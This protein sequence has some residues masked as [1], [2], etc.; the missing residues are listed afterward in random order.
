MF[1][2]RVALLVIA[3]L[4]VSGSVEPDHGWFVA[5]TVLSAVSLLGGGGLI[6]HVHLGGNHRRWRLR[7][8]W[9]D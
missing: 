4:L 8:D 1:P 3:I 5:L 2:V 7:D 6:P 9:D